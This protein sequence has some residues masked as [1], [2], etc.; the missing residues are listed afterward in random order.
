MSHAQSIYLISASQQD[1]IAPSDSSPKKSLL[2]AAME[3]PTYHMFLGA[4]QQALLGI[5]LAWLGFEA[6]RVIY[7]LFFHPLRDFPGPLAARVSGWWI[8]YIEVWKCSSLYIE[9]IEA[10]KKYG[11]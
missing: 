1:D 8:T 10:H 7:N 4:F 3:P 11:M 9:Y 5:I 2:I 6:Y